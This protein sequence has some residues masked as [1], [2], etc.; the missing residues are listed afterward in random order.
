MELVK[1]AGAELKAVGTARKFPWSVLCIRC[2]EP[3]VVMGL[4][5]PDADSPPFHCNECEEDFTE[6]DARRLLTGWGGFL[7]ALDAARARA[8][9]E[10]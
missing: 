4:W 7:A 6:E 8:G 2:G 9:G 5:E 1:L 10:G 3:A